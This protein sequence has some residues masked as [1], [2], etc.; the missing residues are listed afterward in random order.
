MPNA[1]T[2]V[3]SARGEQRIR[4]GH[5]WIYRAEV[6]Q[7]DASGGDI[8]EVIGPRR[9]TLGSALFSDR[10][11]IPVRML[12]HG[13]TIADTALLRARLEQAIA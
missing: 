5:P 8:V 12:T 10:S 7:V 3:V 4:G 2:V 11:Q 13:D 6:V 1:R 9:R